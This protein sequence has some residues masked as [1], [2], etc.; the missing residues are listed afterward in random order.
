MERFGAEL[1]LRTCEDEWRWIIKH[2]MTIA[3]VAVAFTAR[4]SVCEGHDA[5][6]GAGRGPEEWPD[7]T[8]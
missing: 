8:T 1:E 3:M 4:V 7:V 6:Q 2:M 5:E